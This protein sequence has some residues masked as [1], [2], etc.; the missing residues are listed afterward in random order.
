ME[1]VGVVALAVVGVGLALGL[2]IAVRSLPD[3]AHYLR[4]RKM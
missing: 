1:T 4:I 2:V 3:L